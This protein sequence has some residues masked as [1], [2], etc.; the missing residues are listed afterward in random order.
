MLEG[1]TEFF[2]AAAGAA[3]ALAGLIIVAMSVSIDAL[4]KIPGM[5]SRAATAIAMLVAVTV[6]SLAGLI[7]GQGEIAFGIEVIVLALLGLVFAL[8]SLWVLMQHSEG[9]RQ[10]LESVIKAGVGILP[11]AAFAIGGVFVLSAAPVGIILIALGSILAFI[12]AVIDAW[13][14][15]VEIRR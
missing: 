12:V 14:M 9:G 3:A 7:P 4:V 5:T 1:W 8:Q 15:L 11:F 13:V 6:I 2:V 10:V